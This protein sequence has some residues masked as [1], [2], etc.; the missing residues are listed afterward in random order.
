[1]HS[2]ALVY[3]KFL[4]HSRHCYVVYLS[5]N[6]RMDGRLEND[7]SS[8]SSRDALRAKKR[9]LSTGSMRSNTILQNIPPLSNANA[10][11]EYYLTDVI[12]MAPAGWPFPSLYEEIK[13]VNSKNDRQCRDDYD[14]SAPKP[15]MDRG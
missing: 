13:G 3:Q 8:G 5:R 10:Q 15:W 11:G 1:M 4:H 14:G 6:Q 9:I 7:R 12:E 2:F